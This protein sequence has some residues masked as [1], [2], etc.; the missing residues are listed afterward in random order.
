MALR[1][2]SSVFKRLC[3]AGCVDHA[4][5]FACLRSRYEG[6][7]P[8]RMPSGSRLN[9][10]LLFVRIGNLLVV[11]TEHAPLCSLHGCADSLAWSLISCITCRIF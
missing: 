3:L 7:V 5:E 10:L 2:P 9:K 8:A 11:T 4:R 1:I 6:R